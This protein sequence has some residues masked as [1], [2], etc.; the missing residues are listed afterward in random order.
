MSRCL[1]DAQATLNLLCTNVEWISRAVDNLLIQE[2]LANNSGDWATFTEHFIVVRKL[3]ADQVRHCGRLS[4]KIL[5]KIRYIENAYRYGTPE[6]DKASR[7]RVKLETC[8]VLR[9]TKVTIFESLIDRI[10]T[11]VAPSTFEP[12]SKGVNH[13]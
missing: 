3:V 2:K 8:R 12:I 5:N 6:R 7:I 9:G 11:K 1:E 4:E 13:D 10:K